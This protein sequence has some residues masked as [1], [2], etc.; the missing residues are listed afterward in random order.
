MNNRLSS[1]KTPFMHGEYAIKYFIKMSFLIHVISDILYIVK[2][3][4]QIQ[5]SIC[6]DGST[7]LHCVAAAG[8][9]SG[10]WRNRFVLM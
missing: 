2:Q 8:P 9:E 7:A 4:Y 6:P 3:T 10:K 1:D 5:F